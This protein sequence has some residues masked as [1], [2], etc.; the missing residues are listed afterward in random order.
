MKA[1]KYGGLVFLC[2]LLFLSLSIF[3][4][5]F[6][7]NQI[8]MSPSV[9]NSIVRD[10]DMA[11]LVRDNFKRDPGDQTP[12]MQ[13]AIIETINN[14]QPVIKQNLLIA[15]RDG[16]DYI[17]GRS[18]VPDVKAVIGNS[19]LNRN[20]VEQLLA[21]IDIAMLVEQTLD[22][23]SD[24]N[25]E[26]GAALQN[27]LIT[28]VTGIEEEFKR[29]IAD[30][31]DPIFQYILGQTSDI[32][33]TE[34]ARATFLSDSFF[35]HVVANFD[36][37]P[38]TVE[39][40]G[41]QFGPLPQGVTLTDEHIDQIAAKLEPIVKEGLS[42]AAGSLADY[43]TGQSPRFRL[44]VSFA[45][46]LPDLKPIITEAYLASAPAM[47]D[48]A[49]DE[50][51]EQFIELYWD[52]TVSSIPAEITLDS[53]DFG[54]MLDT[55]ITDIL[56][57]FE[58]TLADLRIA[59][60]DF[61]IEIES[62]LVDI[63]EAVGYFQPAYWGIIGL[64]LLAMGL[65]ILITRSIRDSAQALGITFTVYGIL[66]FLSVWVARFVTPNAI[67][68]DAPEMVITLAP[69]LI[70]SLTGPLLTVSIVSLVLGIALIVI[71]VFYPRWKAGKT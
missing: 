61:A 34:T 67:P 56:E 21:Q 5:I 10:I 36:I 27:A 41:D 19:F 54:D 53:R 17:H 33:L 28:A 71:S 22:N 52:M 47:L 50:Q 68:E 26:V 4:L 6:T 7:A 18:N 2:F 43:I 66:A 20:F 38:I 59:I 12:E 40:L 13:A 58:T 69:G 35:G 42:N 64:I 70:N 29:Y 62:N 1:L 23:Q 8:I 24:E 57:D 55:G 45:T 14:I 49:T 11:E 39:M 63:R 44:N 37:K 46:V 3:G 51:K 32:D 30:A 16:Y 60:D 9:V 25:D 48:G 65:I 15:V 31:A